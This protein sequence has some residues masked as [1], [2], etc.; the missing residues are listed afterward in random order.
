MDVIDILDPHIVDTNIEAKTKAEIVNK[1]AN[2]LFENGYIDD[3]HAF[4]DDV[5]LRE[6]E[7]QTGIGD[8]VAIPHSKSMHVQKIG[9]AIGINKTEIPWET[10]DGKGVKV[11]ILFAV[12]NDPEA[13]KDHLKLLSLFAKKLGKEEVIHSLLRAKDTDDVINAFK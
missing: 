11:V 13:A 9:V 5:Y 8:Y 2:D 12:G 10:L 7:G 6:S 4:V 3:I 1:L